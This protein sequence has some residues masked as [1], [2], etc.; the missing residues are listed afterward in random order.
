MNRE[1]EEALQTLCGDSL[2]GVPTLEVDIPLP[3][4]V[5]EMYLAVAY[6]DKRTGEWKGRKV[7]HPKLLAWQALA[8]Q[9]LAF[10]YRL[11]AHAEQWQHAT[12]IGYVATVVVPTGASDTSNRLKAPEDVITKM[13]GMNDNKAAWFFVLR[14]TCGRAQEG[15]IA[16]R[17]Y[18]VS[19][20][21]KRHT[22]R[23]GK[24]DGQTVRPL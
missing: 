20:S 7:P 18:L 8:R 14:G 10:E 3:P 19:T 11:H 21:E 12:R 17:L 2:L 23:K 24:R 5:N 1:Q 16:V 6:Q 15:H 9:K 13:L 22:R 4:S